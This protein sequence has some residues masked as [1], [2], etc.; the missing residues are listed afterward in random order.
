MECEECGH[1]TE[2]HNAHGCGIPLYMRQDVDGEY[3]NVYCRC[4]LG[5]CLT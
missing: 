2:D 4:E 1:D 3:I 5:I